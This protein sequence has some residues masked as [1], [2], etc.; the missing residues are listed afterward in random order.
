[1]KNKDYK[2]YECNTIREIWVEDEHEFPETIP[3]LKCGKEAI[4]K[5]SACHTICHQGKAGNYKNGYTSS[6][7][8]IKKS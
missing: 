8:S 2:C 5:F 7:V 3:C 4:K 1:M 6:P